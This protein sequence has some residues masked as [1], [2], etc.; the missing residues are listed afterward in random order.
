ME[1][2]I[3]VVIR[4]RARTNTSVQEAAEA[5]V[6]AM[7]AT[8][9]PGEPFTEFQVEGDEEWRWVAIQRAEHV[10]SREASPE[11]PKGHDSIA[12]DGPGSEPR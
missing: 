10:S 9:V 7:T 2:D 6:E 8:K 1:H 3:V 12:I 5:V 11:A 4:V